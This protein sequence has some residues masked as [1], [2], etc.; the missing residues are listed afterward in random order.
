MKEK[1]EELI[2]EMKQGNNQS[3]QELYEK[4]KDQIHIINNSPSYCIIDSLKG[5]RIPVEFM[6]EKWR[7]EKLNG[8]KIINVDP[9]NS[10]ENGDF[11]GENGE[12]S[13]VLT[14]NI[15]DCKEHK[16]SISGTIHGTVES[17]PSGIKNTKYIPNQGSK[18][19]GIMPASKKK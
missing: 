12:E 13:D 7:N 9:D 6:D 1:L 5:R 8:D 19:N 10:E 4:Y 2:K 18:S 17:S 3:M 14:Y 11:L 15:T 16:E